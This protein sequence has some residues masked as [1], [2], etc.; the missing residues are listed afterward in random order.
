MLKGDYKVGTISTYFCCF[1]AIMTAIIAFPGMPF[2]P[3][4]LDNRFIG[5]VQGSAWN[6]LSIVCLLF[7]LP[8][9]KKSNLVK[10]TYLFVIFWFISH[11]ERVDI[12]GIL[13]L[14]LIYIL[15]KKEKIKLRTYIIVGITGITAVFT[16]VFLG[17]L[18]ADNI[19]D[20]TITDIARKTLVQNTAAD[21]G[22]VFNTSIEYAETNELLMGKTY[23]TYFIKLVPFL[24]SNVRAGKILNETY[25]TPGGEFILSEPLM[26]FGV[27]GI[28]LFQI[29]E[30]SIYSAILSKKNRY[31]FFL[32]SFLMLTVFR[33]S[34]YGWMYIEKAIVYFIPIIYCITKILDNTER[35]R[36]LVNGVEENEGANQSIIL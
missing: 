5:L 9:F 2:D 11:Y 3:K 21:V 13:L 30:F 20:M 6:H 27:I 34:W 23:I 18:R 16:M 4:Y 24:D 19:Q 22:Y 8:K 7:V 1:L 29:L 35:K 26:N 17:E 31:R 15:I 14:S 25:L 33:T 12:I 10:I 32:Y 28:L 36:N